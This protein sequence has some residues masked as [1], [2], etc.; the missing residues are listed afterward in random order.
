MEESAR[1]AGSG[2]AR[3]GIA[4]VAEDLSAAGETIKKDAASLS[5]AAKEELRGQAEQLSG[6]AAQSLTAFA[7]AVKK[8]G[9]ELKQGD[10]TFAAKLMGEA[11]GG[12]Q[13]LSRSLSHASVEDVVSSVRDFGRSNPTAFLAGSV[14][15]GI[16]LG[17]F[18]R[19]SARHAPAASASGQASSGTSPGRADR[20]EAGAS[21]TRADRPPPDAGAEDAPGRSS[22]A[23]S[24]LWP[25]RNTGAGEGG[26]G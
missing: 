22:V 7:E 4:G 2:D 20:F 13:S 24:P 11:A 9:E 25:D 14:L 3:A 21:P 6:T 10:Q 26:N 23:A 8:A 19:S 18:A 17:R 16:A 1:Q 15:A 5:E 12:L